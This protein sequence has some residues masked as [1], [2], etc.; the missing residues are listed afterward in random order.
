MLDLAHEYGSLT[1]ID[2][3]HAVGLYGDNGAGIG[4]RDNVLSKMD[5]ISGTL[6]QTSLSSVHRYNRLINMSQAKHSAALVATSPRIRSSR[7][8]F[9]AMV[10]DLS[11]QH[12]CHRQSWPVP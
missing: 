7:I 8:S 2:E 5:I 11:S 10:R 6:G 1:F 3:V 9:E 12:R 4:E